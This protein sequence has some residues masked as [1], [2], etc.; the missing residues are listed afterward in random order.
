MV[1]F[2]ASLFGISLLGLVGLFS[3]KLWEISAGYEY[4]PALRRRADG[5]ALRIKRWVVLAARVIEH[6][7]AFVLWSLRFS[8]R[9]GAVMTARVAKSTERGAHWLADMVS[10]KHS[11]ERREARSDFLRRVQEPQEDEE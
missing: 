2:A 10:Y 7:P 8:I 1:T 9:Y 5:Q 6:F 4:A 11:F 3:L